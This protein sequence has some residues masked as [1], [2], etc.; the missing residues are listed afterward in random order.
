MF[1][2]LLAPLMLLNLIHFEESD[3]KFQID[4]HGQL[5]ND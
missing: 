4:I 3:D 5:F 2:N 1:R